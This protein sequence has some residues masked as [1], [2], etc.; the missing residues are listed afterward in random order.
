MLKTQ[1]IIW[2]LQHPQLYREFLRRIPVNIQLL[3]TSQP[4]EQN[5]EKAK[6][7]RWCEEKSCD[8]QTAILKITNSP[9]P[10]SFN[11]K[12]LDEIKTATEITNNCPV[13]MGAAGNLEII[14]QL[15]EYIQAT[16][17]IETGVAYGWSSFAF[18]LSLKNRSRAML[19]S[20]D[21][22]Y[23]IKN[24]EKYVGCVVP[25]ELKAMWTLIS[26]PDRDAIPKAIKI[27]PT[28][29]LCHY[30]SD[31]SYAGRLWAY[32]QLWQVLRSGGIFISDDIDD[33][34][35]FRDFCNSI[36]QE[37]LIVKT[38]EASGVKYVGVLIK[39]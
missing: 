12:F 6:V 2:F 19:V 15:T 10:S 32:P 33:N 34:F 35:G 25:N 31:K 21:F 18:L 14:Y 26:Y 36:D 27:L 30:D 23:F 22:P 5:Q 8:T 24:S 37:P 3:F 13:K 17:I 39:P 4:T 28:I 16:R 9:I 7:K 29:D 38:W 11:E 20:T 1:R